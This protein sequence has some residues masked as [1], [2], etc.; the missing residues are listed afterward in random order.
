MPHRCLTVTFCFFGPVAPLRSS[1]GP[2]IFPASQSPCQQFP[3]IC[4]PPVPGPPGAISC[5]AAL[6][7]C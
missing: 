1:C 6:V 2:A 4:V 7:V 3:Q 5:S